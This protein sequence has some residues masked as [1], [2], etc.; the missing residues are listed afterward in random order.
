[1]RK[2]RMLHSD[3]TTCAN[4]PSLSGAAPVAPQPA[5]AKPNGSAAKEEA[6]E[7]RKARTRS[8]EDEEEDREGEE[9]EEDSGEE[10]EDDADEANISL[11]MMFSPSFTTA[12]WTLETSADSMYR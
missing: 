2:K 10:E 9:G 11:A 7:K 12:Q 8:D 4:H 3:P 1:M 6:E 5:A